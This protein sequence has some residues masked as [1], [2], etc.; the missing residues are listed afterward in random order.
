[1]KDRLLRLLH[2]TG[3]TLP[4]LAAAVS[5]VVSGVLTL[6][7]PL[8]VG[9]AIDCI[10]SSPINTPG[11]AH[12][13]RLLFFMY[14]LN[15]LM[16]WGLSQAS[17]HIGYRTAETLRRAAC[18]KLHTLPVKAIDG[19]PAGDYLSMML[20]DAEAVSQ[21]IIQG[22]PR[23]LTGA[24]AILGTIVCM[25]S[26]SPW[27]ALTVVGL[28]PLSYL[29]ARRI[30]LASHTLF[31]RQADTQGE[32]TAFI[33]E[34]IQNH[35]LIGFFSAQESSL[36]AFDEH[37]ETLYHHS[38]K[39]Q[40]YSAL[41][42]PLTR[43]VNHL[44]YVA[45]GLV[46]GL[47]A[48]HG[49]LSVGQIASLLSYANQY[50]KPFNEISAVIH[51]LQ[52]ADAALTRLFALLDTPDEAPDPAQAL[53][54][55]TAAGDVAFRSVSFR[56]EEDQPLIENFSLSVRPGQKVA[57]V[58][59]TGAGKTTLVNLLMRFYDADAGEILI[60]G[61]PIRSMRRAALR[62]LFAM[63]L[64]DSWLFSGTV[65]ENI[66]FGKPDATEEEIV[67]A[68][69]R[70]HV[71]GFIMRLPEGYDTV[72][73]E[74]SRLSAGQTQLISIARVLLC[75]P[76]L[77]ILDEATSSVDTRTELYV[78]RAFD[79]MMQDRTAFVIAHRLSTIRSSDLILVLEDGH[80]RETG[81]HETLLAKRGFYYTMYMSQFDEEN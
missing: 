76:P 80:I 68:A 48:A 33:S 10:A 8:I 53:A 49:A 21:G 55:Q 20:Q 58:G 37:N 77:L 4:A 25:L 59:P 51:Q 5:A 69:K 31:I 74:H 70:A 72:L 17:N 45:V 75:D 13:V 44:V 19:R 18:L 40:L 9:G 67:S 56:Y 66:A 50:T 64:Q 41:I 24:V 32:V 16:Q 81:T 57:I 46:G 73:D 61:T 71:H 79:E 65:R 7:F 60:D 11:L 22:V 54:P 38:F 62:S 23:L 28:T 27:V 12:Y 30:T 63:V 26:I 78:S 43:F 29:V 14:L 42:N 1:M 39:A 47:M 3:L 15:A 34:R 6:V 2:L 35:A 36:N 52:A